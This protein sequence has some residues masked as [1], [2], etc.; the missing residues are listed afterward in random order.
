MRG[1]ADPTGGCTSTSTQVTAVEHDVLAAVAEHLGRAASKDL[2]ARCKPGKG[3][4]HAG[5]AE[6]RRL[7]IGECSSRWS[8]TFTRRAAALRERR[9]LNGFCYV[10]GTVSLV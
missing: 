10:S 1:L 6:R 7:L 8:G 9:K 3:P 4:G 5:R 2:A